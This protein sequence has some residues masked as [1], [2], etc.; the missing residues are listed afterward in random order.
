MCFTGRRNTS[1]WET[2]LAAITHS[3]SWTARNHPGLWYQKPWHITQHSRPWGKRRVDSTFKKKKNSEQCQWRALWCTQFSSDSFD[4]FMC[5]GLHLESSSWDEI[6]CFLY[7]N[8]RPIFFRLSSLI[9]FFVKGYT[10]LQASL[11]GTLYFLTAVHQR[12]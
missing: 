5:W 10:T 2:L 4:H 11:S 8:H 3:A 7:S 6:C 12:W 1:T 9:Y